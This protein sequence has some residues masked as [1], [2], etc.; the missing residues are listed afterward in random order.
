ML[1]ILLRK[2]NIYGIIKNKML[3]VIYNNKF[4]QK[5]RQMFK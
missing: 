1:N 3:E 2:Q 4:L 5:T